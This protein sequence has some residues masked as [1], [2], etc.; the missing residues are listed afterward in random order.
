MELY[1]LDSGM[2]GEGTIGPE[3]DRFEDADE[4]IR[5]KSSVLELDID[6]DG[7]GGDRKPGLGGF[8]LLTERFE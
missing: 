5:E 4:E 7:N 6:R 8:L 1:N 3:T 2:L